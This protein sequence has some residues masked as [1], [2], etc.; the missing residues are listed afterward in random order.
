MP[1]SFCDGCR[2]VTLPFLPHRPYGLVERKRD[3][4]SMC[5]TCQI[6]GIGRLERTRAVGKREE[7]AS[8]REGGLS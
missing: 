2:E 4:L 3:A 6:A 8:P 7:D 1:R 5:A